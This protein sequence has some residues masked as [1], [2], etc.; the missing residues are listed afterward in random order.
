ML[1]VVWSVFIVFLHHYIIV[2]QRPVHTSA[3]DTSAASLLCCVCVSAPTEDVERNAQEVTFPPPLNGRM[4][5]RAPPRLCPRHGWGRGGA[6]RRSP[7]WPLFL[8]VLF[9]V[10]GLLCVGT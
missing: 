4:Q 6:R 9:A 3:V 10:R 1:S 5:R 7:R 8:V 2:K